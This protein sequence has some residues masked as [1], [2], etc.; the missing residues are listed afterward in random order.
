MLRGSYC[1][2]TARD[3]QRL[4]AFLN[5]ISDGIG[6]A[7]LVNIIVHPQYQQQGLGTKL[8]SAAVASLTTDG[9]QCIWTTFTPEKEPFYRDN[10]FHI[11]R[12]GVIDNAHG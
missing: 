3:R 8:I 10:G 9:I 7:L 6:D 1:Y 12:G 5:V 4:A 2:F 11:L